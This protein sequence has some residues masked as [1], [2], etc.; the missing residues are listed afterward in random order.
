VVLGTTFGTMKE[1][2]HVLMAGVPHDV[3]AH[4]VMVRDSGPRTIRDQNRFPNPP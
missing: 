4:D 1:A 3:D 2:T